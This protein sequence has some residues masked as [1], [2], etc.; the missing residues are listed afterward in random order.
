M[1]A[2]AIYTSDF[3][4]LTSAAAVGSQACTEALFQAHPNNTNMVLL[5]NSSTQA[6]VLSAGGSVAL[7]ISNINQIYVKSNTGS[8]TVIWIAHTKEF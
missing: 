7:P 4:A 5:G 8:A 1:P 6:I 2:I 3:I